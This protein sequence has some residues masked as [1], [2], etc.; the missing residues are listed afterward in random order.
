MLEIRAYVEIMRFFF[1][2]FL[3]FFLVTNHHSLNGMY[4]FTETIGQKPRQ[5]TLD[6][7]PW[8]QVPSGSSSNSLPLGEI[9]FLAGVGPR[10]IFLT[11]CLASTTLSS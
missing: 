5:V 4:N 8:L 10:C 11:D 7:L 3:F 2:F 1:V 6:S 9:L